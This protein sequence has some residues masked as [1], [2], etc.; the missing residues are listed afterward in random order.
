MRIDAARP[1][2]EKA[3]VVE[4]KELAEVDVLNGSGRGTERLLPVTL[5][6]SFL[7]LMLKV[8]VDEEIGSR[9]SREVAVTA[10]SQLVLKISAGLSTRDLTNAGGGRGVIAAWGGTISAEGRDL[11]TLRLG[12]IDVERT[13]GDGGGGDPS[14]SRPKQEPTVHPCPEGGRAPPPVCC[15][16]VVLLG[17]RRSG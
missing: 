4:L 10:P 17:M 15:C 5:L 3:I 2:D 12:R 16:L 14:R 13:R 1:S 9:V 7:L 6:L 8:T 11:G